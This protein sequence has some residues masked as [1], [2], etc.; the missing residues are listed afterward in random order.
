MG[1]FD[2]ALSLRNCAVFHSAGAANPIGK[3]SNCRELLR[4]ESAHPNIGPMSYEY[5][6]PSTETEKCITWATKSA[7]EIIENQYASVSNEHLIN[8]IICHK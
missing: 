5:N 8:V 1:A 6:A 7:E 2:W 4:S 3:L